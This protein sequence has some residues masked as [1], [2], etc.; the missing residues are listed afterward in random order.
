MEER[1]KL[2]KEE[3]QRKEWTA[4]SKVEEEKRREEHAK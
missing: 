4:R 3:N 2:E 1:Q